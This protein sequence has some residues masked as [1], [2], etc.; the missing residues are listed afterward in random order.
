MTTNQLPKLGELLGKTSKPQSENLYVPDVVG[1][2]MLIALPEKVEKKGSVYVPDEV[3]EA[4]RA[5]TVIGHVL[6]QGP[7]CYVGSFPNGAPRF[8]GGAW[9][10]EGDY[11]VFG[12][13]TGHRIRIGGV[14]FRILADDQILATIDSDALKEI[15]GL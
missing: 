15:S 4:E 14:E 9:C 11:V 2:Y 6:K 10:K 13:Y 12:R 1:H 8:P 7:D 3:A 5:A